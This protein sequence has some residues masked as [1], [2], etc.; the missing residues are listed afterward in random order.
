MSADEEGTLERLKVQR[1]DLID[2]AIALHSGR[3]VKTVGDGVLVEFASAVDAVRCAV[4]V[5]R[6]IAEQNVVVPGDRRI[7]LR[8]GIHVGDVI[9]EDGDIYGD[10][11][12]IASRLEAIAEPGDVL[13]SYAVHDLVRD[14]P[15][16]DFEDLGERELKNIPR[17]MRVY[18]VREA[19]EPMVTPA[20]GAA[21]PLPARPSIAVL[22]FSNM[23]GD[24]EQEHFADGI[25]EDIITGLSRLKWL[26]VIAR[27]S[28]FTYKGRAVDVREVGRGLGV[29]YI[30]EGSVRKSGDRIRVTGQL[31]EAETGN[32]LWADRYDRALEDV[33][34]IQDEITESVIGCIQPEVY[35]AEHDRA[36]RKPPQSLDAW[37]S[38]IRA[39]FLFSQHS[40]ASTREALDLLDRA[41]TLD[42]AYAQAHGL[43]G[44]C[45]VWRA[46]QGWEDRETAFT[47]AARAVDRGIA[48]DPGEPWAFLARCA[49]AMGR[50]QESEAINAI[51]RTIDLSPNFA[52]AHALL[53]AVHAFGGRSEQ[54]IECIDRGVRLSPRDVFDADFRL[55]YA[56]AY[57]PAG[58]YAEAASAAQLVIQHQP[59]H[60]NAYVMAAAA[61]GLAGEA[62]QAGEL[63]AQLVKLVPGIS[64][65]DVEESFP[66]FRSEDRR[67]LAEGLRAGGLPG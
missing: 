17:P 56:F 21:L 44:W 63:V 57:F 40:D 15:D 9:V 66:Y 55:F 4:G 47:E 18:R 12:N 3:I 22:P 25:A 52:Y 59:A 54:A 58:R 7:E 30:L 26:F 61:H 64:A 48:C 45:L 50:L 1:R 19:A 31:I 41:V 38:F 46:F 24:P 28:S 13:I 20:A 34:A 62:D 42:P 36:K 51:S 67:R 23:S 10:G 49:V 35:A 39:M 14:R 60:P 8:I 16:V 32:H 2:P 53:G 33:F 65:K 43:R 29:R 37:E 6:E 27:N 5:Q 11:V